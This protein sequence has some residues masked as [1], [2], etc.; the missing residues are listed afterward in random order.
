MDTTIPHVLPGEPGGDLSW[1][2]RQNGF[3]Q[4]EIL[5]QVDFKRRHWP[6]LAN[7]HAVIHPQH[8]Y[9][10]VL[11]E[12]HIAKAFYPPIAEAVLAYI[13]REKI[14][15]HT[16]ALNLKSSQAACFN[17]LFPLRQDPVLATRVFAALFPQI[18]AV[19]GIEFEYTGP[20]EATGWLGEPKNGKRG[21]NRTSI[22]AAVFYQD[23]RGRKGAILIEW[24]YTERSFGGCSAFSKASREAKAACIAMDV[25]AVQKPGEGCILTSKKRHCDR[26]YWKY[27]AE[28]GIDLRAFAGIRGCPFQGP[29][30]QLMR[31]QLLGAYLKQ[32][33][34]VDDF[35]V[36]SLS[37][38]ENADL[39]KLPS[40]LQPLLGTQPGA[41]LDAWNAVLRGGAAVRSLS[42]N[43]LVKQVDTDREDLNAWIGYLQ[44]RY[45]V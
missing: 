24:K 44:G 5:R 17:F 43:E 25:A 2:E 20:S 28:A 35:Q 21:Q 3:E 31:Q 8:T 27:M 9:P 36:A 41:V 26:H 15:L 18:S 33:G 14:V 12:G 7:G 39:H 23:A 37:F 34:L 6:E 4:Q 13:R 10:H 45:G 38:A 29:F 16:E 42:A 40:Q 30:Y 1:F 22:D 11:P 19:T 32:A